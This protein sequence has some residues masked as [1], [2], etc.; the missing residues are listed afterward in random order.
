M[1]A[2]SG[3]D[4]LLKV[5]D[6]SGLFDDANYVVVGGFTSNNINITAQSVDITNKDSNGFSEMLESAGNISIS[7]GGDGVF[8]DDA[9]F[10]RVHDH[11]LAQTHPD[12]KLVLPG[13]AEYTGKFHISSLNITGNDN[14]A[15]TYAIT[16]ESAGVVTVTPLP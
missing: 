14:Q 12:C 10:Q 5:H 7:A 3:R 13:F 2:Q 6:G 9:S 15:I 16:L 4:L 8:V 11:V 1:A